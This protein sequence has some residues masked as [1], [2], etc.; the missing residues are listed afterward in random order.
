MG[1]SAGKAESLGAQGVHMNGVAV[2]GDFGVL[3]PD[4]L[5]HIDVYHVRILLKRRGS[6]LFRRLGAWVG[7]AEEHSAIAFPDDRACGASGGVYVK[8]D[9]SAGTFLSAQLNLQFQN[10]SFTNCPVLG[11]AV[12]QV[13]QPKQW[14]WKGF[15]RQ[16]LQVEW[17]RKNVRPGNGYVVAG[18]ESAYT[19]I[20]IQIIVGSLCVQ[21][22]G[23]KF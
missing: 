17:K 10:L 21:E 3:A 1:D 9:S 18:T 20:L 11:N 2:A 4:G 5:R 12:T 14:Q 6:G 19:L 15:F 23:G 22:L 13:H 16:Q 8:L 7:L